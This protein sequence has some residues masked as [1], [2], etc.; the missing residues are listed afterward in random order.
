MWIPRLATHH[1]GAAPAPLF[2]HVILF[3]FLV[4]FIT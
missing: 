2:Y 1:T 3:S 4:I